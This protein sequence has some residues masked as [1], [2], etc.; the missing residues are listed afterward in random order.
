MG[1]GRPAPNQVDYNPPWSPQPA[2][3]P[4]MLQTATRQKKSSDPTRRVSR[5][6]ILPDLPRTIKTTAPKSTQYHPSLSSEYAHKPTPSLRASYRTSYVHAPADPRPSSSRHPEP[7]P[8]KSKTPKS[9]FNQLTSPMPPNVALSL[10]YTGSLPPVSKSTDPAV[11]KSSKTRDRDRDR[12]LR[13]R[14]R[15]RPPDTHGRK[16]PREASRDPY[17]SRQQIYHATT[18]SRDPK[19]RLDENG[20]LPKSSGHRRH[21]TEDDAMTLKVNRI[22]HL[23]S[24]PDHFQSPTPVS[25]ARRK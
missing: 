21:L 22:F 2:Q 25:A 3:E 9:S 17:D 4:S 24:Q 14:E 6:S 23:S 11:R 16:A 10:P 8:S 13:G 19:E 12:D 15:D 1:S 7:K 5:A 18:L 20:V